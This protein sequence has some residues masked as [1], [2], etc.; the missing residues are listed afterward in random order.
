MLLAL[1]WNLGAVVE[2]GL[3]LVSNYGM[4]FTAFCQQMVFGNRNPGVEALVFK[5]LIPF[6]MDT[7]EGLV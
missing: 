7:K 4:A 5:L 6:F 1:L 3:F 2:K